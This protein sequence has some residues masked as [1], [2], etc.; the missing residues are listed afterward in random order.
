MKQ[1]VCDLT[2]RGY[3]SKIL[4]CRNAAGEQWVEDVYGVDADNVSDDLIDEIY[5]DFKAGIN[6][7]AFVEIKENDHVG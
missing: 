5:A 6:L 4:I 7:E 1:F 2:S 3:A